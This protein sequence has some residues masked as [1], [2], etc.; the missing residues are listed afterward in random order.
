MRREDNDPIDYSLKHVTARRK[1]RASHPNPAEYSAQ[2]SP[3]G[4][5]IVVK[6]DAPRNTYA[7]KARGSYAECLLW[8]ERNEAKLRAQAQAA[9]A[10]K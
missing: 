10:K 3:W 4:V 5:V 6:G 8:K 9:K 1:A 2:V 7:V